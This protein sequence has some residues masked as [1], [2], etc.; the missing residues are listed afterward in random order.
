MNN[1]DGRREEVGMEGKEGLCRLNTH[2]RMRAEE[3]MCR[4]NTDEREMGEDLQD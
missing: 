3:R 2:G 4:I 1:G